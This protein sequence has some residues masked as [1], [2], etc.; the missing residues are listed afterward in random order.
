M[1]GGG[2]DSYRRRH[3]GIRVTWAGVR[4]L[5]VEEPG[6]R[7]RR[8]RAVVASLIDGSTLILPA[9]RDGRGARRA[10]AFAVAQ[11]RILA[12]HETY[13]KSVAEPRDAVPEEY[14]PAFVEPIVFYGGRFAPARWAT[15]A[16]RLA[17]PGMITLVLLFAGSVFALCAAVH[18]LA[19]DAP[20]Y[21]AF[22]SPIACMTT[23]AA[24]PDGTGAFCVVGDGRV[25]GISASDDGASSLISLGP[26]SDDGM[27][28]VTQYVWFTPAEAAPNPG[29]GE[30]VVFIEGPT[31]EV[32]T[33]TVDGVTYQAD[34]S[35]QFQRVEDVA[36]ISMGAF[37]TLLFAFWIG[38]RA[39][40][41]RYTPPRITVLAALAAASIACLVITVGA[42][43]GSGCVILTVGGVFAVAG[44]VTG[45]VA[46]V[47]AVV[48]LCV[49]RRAPRPLSRRRRALP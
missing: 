20:T 39:R 36:E 14:R 25:V 13:Q 34:G 32:V 22:R 8:R 21:R 47:G 5:R 1:D 11:A 4:A 3:G 27:A 40:R 37:W 15:A 18:D 12:A 28:D 24:D 41:R 49:R 48:S 33:L 17:R 31:G 19:R 42:S 9:P 30:S 23:D 45:C 46:A 29:I 7:G 10:A 6:T 2:I 44:I 16:R 38:F 26:S 43:S 35:P